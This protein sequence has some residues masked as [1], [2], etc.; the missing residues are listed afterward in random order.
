MWILLLLLTWYMKDTD[1]GIIN[2]RI[3]VTL[4]DHQEQSSQNC[5]K[6]VKKTYSHMFTKNLHMN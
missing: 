2:L 4:C 1:Y 3:V 6:E 5:Q